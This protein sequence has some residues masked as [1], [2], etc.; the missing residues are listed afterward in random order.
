MPRDLVPSR[1]GP[2]EEISREVVKH[3]RP[4]TMPK[5]GSYAPRG[6]REELVAKDFQR[7][8]DHLARL[9]S[10]SA[11]EVMQQLPVGVLQIYLLAEEVGQARE[12]ILHAFP[13]PGAKARSRYLPAV[14]EIPATV[15]A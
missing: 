5:G 10:A 1:E 7:A 2:K 11:V 4:Y 15:G 13:K 9:N 6:T 3:N 14:D 12:M 8:K